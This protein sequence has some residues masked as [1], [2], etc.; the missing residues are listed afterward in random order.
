MT[1]GAG[2]DDRVAA[3]AALADITALADA[4]RDGRRAVPATVTTPP[5][6]MAAGGIGWIRNWLRRWP[7]ALKPPVA[8]WWSTAAAMPHAPICWRSRGWPIR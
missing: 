2:G 6:L 8:G 4:I 5:G 7:R 1:G 3:V